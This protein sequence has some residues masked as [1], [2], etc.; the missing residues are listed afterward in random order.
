[1]SK[2]A[3]VANHST[4]NMDLQKSLFTTQRE[5]GWAENS[6]IAKKDITF[7]E[8]VSQICCG[9]LIRCRRERFDGKPFVC[10]SIFII[11]IY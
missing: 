9:L 11:S 1:M 10:A 6:G 5:L 3:I 4:K 2:H 7:T 8:Y